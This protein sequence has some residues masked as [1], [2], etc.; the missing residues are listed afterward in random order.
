MSNPTNPYEN[1]DPA[2]SPESTTPWP[3]YGNGGSAST[4]Y[5]NPGGRAGSGNAGGSPY[6]PATG[7]AGGSTGRAAGGANF[8]AAG[9]YGSTPYGGGSPQYV[10]NVPGGGNYGGFESTVQVLPSRAGSIWMIVIGVLMAIVLAPG[11]L[12]GT[13]FYK[14]MNIYDTSATEILVSP[15][16]E[17]TID[18]NGSLDLVPVGEGSAG[19]CALVDT[20][21][22][23]H[24]MDYVSAYDS[25]SISGLEVGQYT[26]EC[27]NSVGVEFV[28]IT[29]EQFSSLL[30][31]IYRT[32]GVS[33]IIGI[34][35][36]V[37]AVVGIVKLSGVN[38]RRREIA[39]R[40]QW[41][42]G[43]FPA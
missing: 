11:V 26:L 29:N 20:D 13:A 4:G 8:G 6:D 7:T 30:G 32:F 21:G 41:G 38:Q 19:D 27:E 35:G 1:Y 31:T 22:T 36:L 9:S 25:Y 39:F 2:D 28:S 15:G 37:I 43:G 42:G 5:G 12:F 17:V 3:V 10:G 18:E 16:S 24:G 34:A 14:L 40:S 33:T 23:E